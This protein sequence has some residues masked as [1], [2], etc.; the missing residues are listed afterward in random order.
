MVWGIKSCV[1]WSWLATTSKL[2]FFWKFCC[3]ERARSGSGIGTVHTSRNAGQVQASHLEGL[4][5]NKYIT[6]HGETELA[7]LEEAAVCLLVLAV[8]RI[9]DTR[10]AR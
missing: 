2:P 8:C 9:G 1:T 6:V 10:Q 4:V 5:T 3:G 7:A